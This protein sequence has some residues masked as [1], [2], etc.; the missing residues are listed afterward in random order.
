MH[1]NVRT[2]F[3]IGLTMATLYSIWVIVVYVTRGHGPFT[4]MGTSLGAVLLTY[5][6]TGAL[7]G[8]LVGALLPFARTFL[9]AVALGV[10][11]GLLLLLLRGNRVERSVLELGSGRVGKR[12]RVGNSYGCRRRSDCTASLAS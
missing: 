11:V 4:A 8:L 1:K 3:F 10:L 5:Y 7:G 9:G 6:T 12:R 2:T